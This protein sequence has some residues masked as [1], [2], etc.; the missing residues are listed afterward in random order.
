[1]AR[2]KFAKLKALMFEQDVSQEYLA[3][4]MGRC[5]TYLSRRMNAHESFTI[6]DMRVISAVLDIPR[7]Q[8]LDYFMEPA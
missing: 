7:E 3:K 2:R 5:V 8:W 6:E 4:K 1:M